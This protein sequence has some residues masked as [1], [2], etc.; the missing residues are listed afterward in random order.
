MPVN[1]CLHG[2]WWTDDGA[3]ALYAGQTTGVTAL[4]D[5][6]ILERGAWSRVDG[7]LPPD[8]NLYAHARVEGATVVFGGQALDGG[9][10]ADTW[11]LEDGGA[12]ARPL[13]VTGPAPG[14]RAGAELIFD[15]A[16]GRV[17]LFGGR[18]SDGT[19]ADL[20]ELSGL[21]PAG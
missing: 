21:P 10:L 2:C 8:R 15:R 5:R 6:W 4:G 1:R 9:F 16:Q 7:T 3:F 14:G 19:Y 11:V 17:L 20:W 12:D 13:E 18:D